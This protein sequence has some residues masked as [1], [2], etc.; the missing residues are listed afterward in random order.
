MIENEF[1]IM[2]TKEQYE[3]L[4]REFSWD[5]EISQTNHYFDTEELLLSEWRITV[6]VREIDG[7]YFLQ[8]K[9]PTD[10][11]FSRIEIEQ[12]LPGLPE[13]IWG[14]ALSAFSGVDGLPSVK[15]LGKL[16][17]KRSVKRFNCAELDLDMSEYF[18]KRDYEAEI[19][20]TDENEARLLLEKIRGII[21]E[22]SAGEV[23]TGKI[24][25][26]L[27]EFR[28]QKNKNL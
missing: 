20:F 17:T 1:K 8:M 5:K 23:C 26:F 12:K 9:L 19:E 25:R 18:D 2:L 4:Y 28:A 16:F 14:A 11:E 22:N 15:L 21:G 7:E 27:D 3:R 13:N 24:H 6:R 10:R